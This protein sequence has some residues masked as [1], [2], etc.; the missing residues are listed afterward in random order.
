MLELSGLVPLGHIDIVTFKIATA[1]VIEKMN[2][3]KRA[4]LGFASLDNYN[5]FAAMLIR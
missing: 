4:S 2:A 5:C 1:F 3:W